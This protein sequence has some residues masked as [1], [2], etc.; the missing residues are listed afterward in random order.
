MLA[1]HGYPR[2]KVAESSLA[3]MVLFVVRQ[4]SVL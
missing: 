1:D 4:C 3:V 2:G